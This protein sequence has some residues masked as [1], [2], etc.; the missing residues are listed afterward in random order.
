MGLFS[1]FLGD[2][3]RQIANN[4]TNEVIKKTE[5]QTNTSSH[6]QTEDAWSSQEESSK[7][8]G[9]SGFS[10]GPDMPEE[11]NQYSY[12]GN[13]IDYF[14]NIYRSEFPEYRISCTPSG[15]MQYALIVFSQNDR[16]AL[17]VELLSKSSSVKKWRNN[18]RKSGIPYLRYYHN[19]D[20]WWNTRSYVI[21]RTRSALSV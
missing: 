14:M 5:H 15:N 18:C 7:K 1:K 2:L 9:P 16:T 10:W 8:T 4:L 13:Y 11:E 17:I 12:D 19:V 21:T 6:A 3:N 20:G